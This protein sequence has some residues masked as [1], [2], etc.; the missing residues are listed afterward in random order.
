MRH[1]I[2]MAGHAFRLRP[3]ELADAPLIISLRSDA[4]R[5]RY[6]HGVPLDVAAQEE[7]LNNYFSRPGDY[8][9]VIQRLPAGGGGAEGLI[10]I[11]D[12]DTK[13]RCGSWGR[14]IVEPRSSAAIESAWLIYRIGFER[15]SLDQMYT[16]TLVENASVLSFHDRAGL[17]RRRRLDGYYELGG[18]R[19]DAIE[20][21]LTRDRWPAT[22]INLERRAARLASR[23][24][25]G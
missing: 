4:D 5:T 20:H 24:N 22:S 3:I 18:E 2:H 11:Y 14:W 13:L 21:V 23:L 9:F 19:C 12:V 16:H 17:I 15:L 25:V 7:Y 1:S 10:G 8:Y 6:L